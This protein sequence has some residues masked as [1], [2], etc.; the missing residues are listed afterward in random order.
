MYA[1]LKLGSAIE[2]PQI[3]LTER[4]IATDQSRKFVYIISDE[5]KTTYREVKLGN[6]IDGK[7]IIL[8]GLAVGDKVVTRGL[9]RIRPG[10][11]VDPQEPKATGDAQ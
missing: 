7:R 9:M 5:N 2:Y 11:L 4:A 10:M 6:S 1:R 8:S 3:L